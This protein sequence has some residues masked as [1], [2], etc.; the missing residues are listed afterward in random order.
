M[1][2]YRKFPLLLI[3]RCVLSRLSL[4]SRVQVRDVKLYFYIEK[5]GGILAAK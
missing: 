5:V 1:S 2:K 3:F 4:L